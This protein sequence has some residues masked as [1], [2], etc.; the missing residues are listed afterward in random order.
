MSSNI[1]ED[2]NLTMNVKYC[3]GAREESG[4]REER[5]VDIYQS[6]DSDQHV[7][8]QDRGAHSKKHFA[9][10]QRNRFKPAALVLGL[11]CL[12]LAAG[13]TVLS[14]LY[15]LTALEKVQLQISND[16]LQR[17]FTNLSDSFCQTKDQTKGNI[18]EWR[19]FRCRC[20]FKS[21]ERKSWT[22]SK[23]DCQSRG[24]D[25]VV[26]NDKAEHDFVSEHVDS[27]I[28]LQPVKDQWG[29]AWEW[30][31]V[32]KSNTNY[33]PWQPEVMPNPVHGAASTTYINLKGPWDQ[34][35]EGSKRWICERQISSV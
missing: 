19:R 26:I 10:V 14:V 34:T 25:L 24:A 18:T 15:S 20:Y 3:K 6:V 5:L 32:D 11:L 13:V 35:N 31:W 30:Q 17:R 22:E 9:A 4:D 12:L 28:G 23:R 1:Y 27:W 21:T 2:P 7:C 29:K 8:A 16:E 33:W